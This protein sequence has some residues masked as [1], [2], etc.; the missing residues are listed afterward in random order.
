MTYFYRHKKPEVK[1][2]DKLTFTFNETEILHITAAIEFRIDYYSK[3]LEAIENIKDQLKP[4]NYSSSLKDAQMSKDYHIALRDNIK[5]QQAKNEK[6]AKM[7]ED[8][9]TGIDYEQHRNEL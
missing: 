6:L 9:I 8:I 7:S 1:R 3:R 5:K 4:S 2:L